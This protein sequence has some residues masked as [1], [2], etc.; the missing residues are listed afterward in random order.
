MNR[1]EYL[2]MGG[3]VVSGTLAGCSETSADDPDDTEDGG[4]GEESGEPSFTDIGIS[5][6]GSTTVDGEFTVTVSATNE[7]GAA[8]DYEDELVAT[9]GPID[10]EES[11][12]LTDVAPDETAT[13]DFGPFSVDHVTECAF[14][15]SEAD[16]DHELSIEPLTAA[17]G[18]TL[19]L[20]D[21]LR[22]TLTD[23]RYQSSLFYEEYV[24]EL[25]ATQNAGRVFTSP[26]DATLVVFELELE[27]VGT[28][29]VSLS[30][31]EFAFSESE[32]YTSLADQSLESAV[33]DDDPLVGSGE[34]LLGTGVT[35]DFWLLGQLESTAAAGTATL[36]YH[37]TSE[38]AADLQWELPLEGEDG[39]AFPT[40]ELESVDAPAEAS[41]AYD[42]T[43]TIRNTSDVDGRFRGV[44]QYEN[45]DEWWELTSATKSRLDV[46]IAAGESREIRVTNESS[47]SGE[48]TYRLAPFDDEWV[49]TL[50]S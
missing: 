4:N 27:N 38:S 17:V 35:V 23:V 13:A 50:S 26:D 36:D 22:A 16:V 10:L 25:F 5:T 40:F 1:R 32:F 7:G 31:A 45:D 49:T 20:G 24:S 6:A 12:E 29:S 42:I 11:V 37:R 39:P 30:P 41:G 33:I 9:E 2:A 43:A 48:Y 19:S 21:G 3:I 15:L 44:F 14:E 28:S 47:S 18:E 34:T 46:G 8:G